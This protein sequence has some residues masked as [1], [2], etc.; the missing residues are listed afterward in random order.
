MT[1]K[2][3]P[4]GFRKSTAAIGKSTA[5]IGKSTAAIFTAITD[6]INYLYT[7][8]FVGCIVLII[9]ATTS[10]TLSDLTQDP[11]QITR[12]PAY[13]GLIS[14][15]NILFWAFS[16]AIWIFG[17]LILRSKKIVGDHVVFLLGFGL[18]T[19]VLML[20]DFFMI[21]ESFGQLVW[22]G[23]FSTRK[24][25]QAIL[26]A[27]YGIISV[28]F[29]YRYRRVISQTDYVLFF[30]AIIFFGLSLIVDL[31]SALNIFRDTGN[32]GNFWGNTFLHTEEIFK[33]FAIIAWFAYTTR[34]AMKFISAR[35]P[36]KR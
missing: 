22:D 5:A 35:K 34:T 30:I 10:T 23:S 7:R 25:G 4:I 12:Y 6:L 29:A 26:L 24:A 8:N 27:I 18:I 33:F 13:T 11:A 36:A 19:A 3:V 16:S 17:Y 31:S 20:D 32:S 15:I 28:L 9:S 14:N 21:H 1:G 2:G